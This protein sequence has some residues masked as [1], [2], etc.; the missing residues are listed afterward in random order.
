M[1]TSLDQK[2]WSPR[3]WNAHPDWNQIA[4]RKAEQDN[5]HSGGRTLKD[6]IS[7]GQLNEQL[8]G[9]LTMTRYRS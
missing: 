8:D 9:L 5:G 7:I 3:G 1:V 4:K 2:K 6:V